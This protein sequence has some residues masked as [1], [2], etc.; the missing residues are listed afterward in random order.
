MEAARRRGSG[1]LIREVDGE[2]LVLDSIAD[3]IHQLN[4]SAS[5]IWRLYA[6]GTDVPEIVETLASKFDVDKDVVE[7]DVATALARFRELNLVRDA[8]T[9]Q[10]GTE[11]QQ[12]GVEG[13]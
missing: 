7:R 10:D 5:M 4:E 1:L 6:A 8:E 12:G 9:V 11:R 2:I 3:Q 13:T